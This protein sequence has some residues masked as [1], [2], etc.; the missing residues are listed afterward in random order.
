[1]ARVLSL[2]RGSGLNASACE[3]PASLDRDASQT[4]ELPLPDADFADSAD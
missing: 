1:M 3:S 2:V 4:T